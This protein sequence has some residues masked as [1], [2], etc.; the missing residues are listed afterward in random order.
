VEKELLITPRCHTLV[1]RRAMPWN[2]FKDIWE[3]GMAGK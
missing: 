3:K 2:H 1:G